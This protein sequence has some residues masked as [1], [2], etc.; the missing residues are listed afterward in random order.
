[1]SDRTHTTERLLEIR[2]RVNV[3]TPAPWTETSIT[4]GPD[5]VIVDGLTAFRNDEEFV[6]ALA[7]R[8]SKEPWQDSADMEFIAH[9]REDVPYLLTLITLQQEEIDQLRGSD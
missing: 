4:D 9:A 3:A 5:G 7:D 2:A 1:M 8:Y 6:I